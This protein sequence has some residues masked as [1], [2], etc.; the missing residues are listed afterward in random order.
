MKFREYSTTEL[1][2]C[3]EAFCEDFASVEHPTTADWTNGLFDWFRATA[4]DDIQ[5][6]P[7]LGGS[8]KE[9][10]IVDLCHTTY[11]SHEKGLSDE[12]WFRKAMERPCRMKLALESEWGKPQSPGT[13]FSMVL[14]DDCKLAVLRSPV[15]VMIFSSYANEDDQIAAAIR[16]IRSCHDDRDSWLWIDLPTVGEP[17]TGIL[18]G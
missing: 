12:K 14:T 13:T 6:Y 9:E 4:R 18:A 15:K 8:K 2:E 10:F 3:N 16:G 7:P 17:R 11:P 1:E 5:V